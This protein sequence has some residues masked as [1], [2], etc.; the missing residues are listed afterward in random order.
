MLIGLMLVLS[1]VFLLHEVVAVKLPDGR[2]LFGIR[3]VLWLL[4]LI[5]GLAKG[6]HELREAARH[7]LIWP[8]LLL[9][10]LTPF[11]ALIG[12]ING[13]NLPDIIREVYPYTSWVIALVVYANV[14]DSGTLRVLMLFVVLIGAFVTFGTMVEVATVGDVRVVST[15]TAQFLTV[16]IR[17]WPDGWIFMFV[18]MVYAAVAVAARKN[19]LLWGT[20]I[21]LTTAG[22]LLTQMR[23]ILLA[24]FGTIV[25]LILAAKWKRTPWI[26]V[27]ALA[28]PLLVLLIACAI[29][30]GVLSYMLGPDLFLSAA[31]RYSYAQLS[32]D[33]W[34][35]QFEVQHVIAKWESYPLTGVGFGVPYYDIP[36]VPVLGIG[37]IRTFVHNILA[38]Q[39]LKFGPVGLALFSIFCYWVGISFFQSLKDNYDPIVTLP[40]VALGLALVGLVVEA[41]AGNIFGDARQ[42]PI[43]AIVIGLI[44]SAE[45]LLRNQPGITSPCGTTS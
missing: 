29:G 19:R 2:N 12:M 10:C 40:Y 4:V 16:G 34:Q 8:G 31:E 21:A 9:L 6:R 17:V 36:V 26:K 41:Q 38:Y 42:A 27:R 1:N 11:A 7:R 25:L 32:D 39:L 20:V 13:G 33:T 5:A 43:A 14:R 24:F 22:F 18:A 35:R 3:D 28:A 44:A 23:G 45:R 37:D 30:L 15:Y